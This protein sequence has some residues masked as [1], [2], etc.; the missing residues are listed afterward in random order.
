M[1]Q[2][3][4]YVD[5]KFPNHACKLHKSLY[6][7]KQAPRAWFDHF[8][9]QLLHLGFITSLADS[10]LFIYRNSHTTIYLLLYDDDIIITGDHP[11]QISHLITALSL[12][13]ELKDLGALFY[14]LGIQIVP[15]NLASLL[16]SVL[17]YLIHL[18][19]EVWLGH[20]NT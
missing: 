20:S 5:S 12:A 16:I 19:I 10:S 2:P 15:L 11:P 6:G 3:S 13:F 4:T 17:P 8:T 18:S 7:L 1:Q 9:S 14:F